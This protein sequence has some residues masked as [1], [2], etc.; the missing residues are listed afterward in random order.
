MLGGDVDGAFDEQPS[1]NIWTDSDT[2][3]IT[4]RQGGE[5]LAVALWLFDQDGDSDIADHLSDGVKAFLAKLQQKYVRYPAQSACVKWAIYAW[6]HILAAYEKKERALDAE[7]DAE[8]EEEVG[9]PPDPFSPPRRAR[10][11]SPPAPFSRCAM[12]LSN[13]GGSS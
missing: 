9:T 1:E 7:L 13:I 5:M 12:Y 2:P 8:E 3:P 11:P 10:S 4:G 6:P